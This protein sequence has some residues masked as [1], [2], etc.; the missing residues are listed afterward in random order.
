MRKLFFW[1]NNQDKSLAK[2]LDPQKR[3]KIEGIIFQIRKLNPLDYL[4]GYKAIQQMFGVY[5]KEV[6][7]AE[8]GDHEVKKIK[9]HYA[10][11]FSAAVITPKI[12]VKL[13][14]P[15][16]PGLWSEALFNNWD[17]CQRLYDE[18][19]QFTYGKKKRMFFGFLKRS[20]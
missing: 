3:V 14:E 6:K 13:P 19:I 5:Q 15:G 9:E 16:Q 20:S 8:M 2:A 7:P 18:I 1:L 17:I 4:A 11:V 10:H 12:T